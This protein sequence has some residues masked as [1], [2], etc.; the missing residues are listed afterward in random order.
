MSKEPSVIPMVLG[1][2]FCGAMISGIL[3]YWVGRCQ[4]RAET[5]DRAIKAGAAYREVDQD[6]GYVWVVWRRKP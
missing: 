3:F 5:E 6:T 2:L 4:G 1:P